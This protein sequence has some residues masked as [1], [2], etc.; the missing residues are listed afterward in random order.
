MTSV[1]AFILWSYEG[2]RIVPDTSNTSNSRISDKQESETFNIQGRTGQEQNQV[3]PFTPKSAKFKTEEKILNFALQ[4]CQKQT[5][6]LES[7]AQ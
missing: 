3:N 2:L 5:A 4:N 7:T 6:P 1:F